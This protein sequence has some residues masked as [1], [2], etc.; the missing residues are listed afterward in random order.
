MS[1][2]NPYALAG[3]SDTHGFISTTHATPLPSLESN[4]TFACKDLPPLD[5]RSRSVTE[6]TFTN[7]NTDI[8][9]CVVVGPGTNKYF[10]IS[11]R[12]NKT[13]IYKSM[14]RA[15]STIHWTS[16][17]LVTIYHQSGSFSQ[18]ASNFL[19]LSGDGT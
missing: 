7:F 11:T 3:W 1:F 14:N 2:N 13:A 10:D 16:A 4:P 9:N 15:F 12:D 19:E 5:K 17:P 8:T 6:F 18:L